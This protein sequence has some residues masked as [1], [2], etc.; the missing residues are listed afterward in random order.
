[1]LAEGD[2][3]GEIKKDLQSPRKGILFN[4]H[5][6]LR[7]LEKAV[8]AGLTLSTL[9]SGGASNAL[10]IAVANKIF[11]DILWQTLHDEMRADG[12]VANAFE[13]AA[14]QLENGSWDFKNELWSGNVNQANKIIK[15]E[16]AELT[17]TLNQLSNQK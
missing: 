7:S 13:E 14:I 2:C 12:T 1:M 8:K 16:L 6:N 4:K 10:A 3:V 5:D 11:L 15:S 9:S 17:R